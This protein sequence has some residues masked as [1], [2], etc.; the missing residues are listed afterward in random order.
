V[1][2]FWKLEERAGYNKKREIQEKINL[3]LF[4]AGFAFLSV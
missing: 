1:T 4:G 2:S 3:M